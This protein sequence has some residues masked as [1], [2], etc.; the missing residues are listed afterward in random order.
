MNFGTPKINK[1]S[2]F[3]IGLSRFRIRK[4]DIKGVTGILDKLQTNDP[5]FDRM[6]E[7][8][9][10]LSKIEKDIERKHVVILEERNYLQLKVNELTELYKVL[11]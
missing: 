7:I 5:D 9:Y 1:Y 8:N 11:K 4:M 2:H 3:T 6:K 10:K